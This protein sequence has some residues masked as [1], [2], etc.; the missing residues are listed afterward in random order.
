MKEIGIIFALMT[1]LALSKQ[2][3]FFLIFL[4]FLI[5]TD[6]FVNRKRMF[7]V[8]TILFISTFLISIIWNMAVN[9]FYV[10][11]YIGVSIPLQTSFIESNPLNFIGVIIN[12]ILTK[13]FIVTIVTSFVGDFGG[14]G[15]LPNWLISIYFILL[16][17]YV[18]IN[19][20]IR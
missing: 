7:L 16:S 10:P 15:Y 17:C 4:F 5:P 8:F 13:N 19:S 12:T 3:Y 11:S 9:R 20:I 18:N 1:M 6:K 14:T 2:T